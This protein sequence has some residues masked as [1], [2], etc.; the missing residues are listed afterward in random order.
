MIQQVLTDKTRVEQMQADNLRAL[1]P[2]IWIHVNP[3]ETFRLNLNERLQL[4]A[5]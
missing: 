1:T 5:A 3:H 2:L 4:D